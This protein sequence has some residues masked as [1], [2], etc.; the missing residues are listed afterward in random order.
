M[1]KRSD[2]IFQHIIFIIFISL[3]PSSHNYKCTWR[4]FWRKVR[5]T[6]S[7]YFYLIRSL[8][9]TTT[10]SRT[11]ICI[12]HTHSCIFNLHKL[13]YMYIKHNFNFC[14]R[15]IITFKITHN[16]YVTTLNQCG[17]IYTKLMCNDNLRPCNWLLN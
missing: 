7:Y 6:P 13:T 16:I 14:K 4:W 12:K 11:L 2:G 9:S 10:W 1:Y 3:S 15:K 17:N 5:V 8:P